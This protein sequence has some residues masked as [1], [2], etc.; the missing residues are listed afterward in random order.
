MDEAEITLFEKIILKDCIDN[1]K[2]VMQGIQVFGNLF[3]IHEEAQN[4]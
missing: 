1:F 4:F 2:E 3:L